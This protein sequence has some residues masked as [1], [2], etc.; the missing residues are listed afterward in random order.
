MAKRSG[1]LTLHRHTVTTNNK[2]WNL[3]ILGDF[4]IGQTACNENE[5]IK[6]VK[7]IQSKPIS[8]HGVLLTGDLIE[9]VHPTSKGSLFEMA[10]PDPEDQID[11]VIEILEPIKKYILL[12]VD[13]NHEHRTANA[14]GI[15][16][17]KTI[18]TRLGGI[19][20]YG[21]R[22]MIDLT[23][24]RRKIT[25][26]YNIYA[27]HGCGSIPNTVGGRYNKLAKIQ[28]SI[29]ADAYIKGHIHHKLVFPKM[30]WKKE[31]KKV[32]LKKIMFASNGSYLQ[33]AEYAIRSGYDPTEP[34]VAKISLLTDEYDIH[35][36]I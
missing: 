7:Y 34:G 12:M 21:Y 25:Q 17:M 9:N 10:H 20:Y 33:D 32:E 27:E 15:D 23:L 8:E 30:V 2:W 18:A 29:V 1:A 24:K 4:H 31:G 14:T 13:G 5:I 16:V 22:A 11:I 3:L 36:S 28:N 6:M 19:P 26:T 35:A